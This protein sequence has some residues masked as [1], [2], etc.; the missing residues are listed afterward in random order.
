MNIEHKAFGANVHTQAEGII[1]AIVSVFSNTDNAGEKVMPGAFQKSIAHKLPKAVW[2][3]DWRSPIGKTLEVIELQPGD[4]RLP[5]ELSQSGGLYVK[6]QL[7]LRTQRG[8]E[9]YEDLAFG[10]LDEFSIGYQVIKDN[11]D[12][13]GVRELHEILLHE[14]SPVLIGM[15]P[16]T[17]LLSLKNDVA[18]TTRPTTSNTNPVDVP[19]TFAHQAEMLLAGI[20]AFVNRAQIVA[21]LRLKEGRVLSTAN[22]SRIGAA[23][24]AIRGMQSLADDLDALLELTDPDKDKDKADDSE[25]RMLYAEFLRSQQQYGSK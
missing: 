11:V 7:N 25:I 10:S 23:A 15:N 14:W 9:A 16:D 17:Q 18:P 6:G 5:R 19:A 20:E 24:E 13:S 12:T 2:Q 3:H 4:P 1:E 21:S 8:K 22:R